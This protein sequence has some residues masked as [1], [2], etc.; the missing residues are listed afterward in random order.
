MWQF[1]PGKAMGFCDACTTVN[2][3][4]SEII[5]PNCTKCSPWQTWSRLGMILHFSMYCGIESSTTWQL[6]TTPERDQRCSHFHHLK[7]LHGVQRHDKH[8]PQTQGKTFRVILAFWRNNHHDQSAAQ[9]QTNH[10]KHRSLS[11]SPRLATSKIIQS[12]AIRSISTKTQPSDFI[13]L[14]KKRMDCTGWHVS[15]GEVEACQEALQRLPKIE[16]PHL[17]RNPFWRCPIHCLSPCL[18]FDLGFLNE[19][20]HQFLDLDNQQTSSWLSCEFHFGHLFRMSP[21]RKT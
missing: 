2:H 6:D 20:G 8:V 9:L 3:R 19:N 17:I 11:F 12:A 4:F 7:V 15:E 18:W 14:R 1:R 13:T 16:W 21:H 10:E 5:D